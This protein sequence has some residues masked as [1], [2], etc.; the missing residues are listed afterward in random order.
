MADA[1][2]GDIR[3]TILAELA[4]GPAGE[5]AAPSAEVAPVEEAPVDE[6]A[7]EVEVADLDAADIDADDAPL[8]EEAPVED[9]EIE[10]KSDDP[11]EQK[12]LDNVRRAE[13]RMRE[14]AARRDADFQAE[15]QRWQQ[16]VDRVAEIDRLAAR[17]KYDPIPVLRALGVSDEDLVSIA[18]AAFSESPEGQKDPT[19][20][21]HAAAALKERERHDKLT[22]LEKKQ[23]ELEQSIARRE[24]EAAV[25]VEA[26][27]YMRQ[28]NA[29]AA[30]KHPLVSALIKADPEI[31]NGALLRHFELLST[32]LNRAPRPAEVVAAYDKAE[33]ARLTKLGIDPNMVGKA[34]AAAPA[35]ATKTPPAK[36]PANANEP[37]APTSA[38]KLSPTE[39]RESILA[40]LAASRGSN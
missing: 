17:V 33:R 2:A 16:Q 29:T 4:A 35:P 1:P 12:L 7:G 23:Q 3:S 28:L 10:L 40:E 25:R 13:K 14:A 31:A 39:E 6:D 9:E 30:S 18:Q 34:K 15:R 5:E 22:A 8:D 32:K 21:A 36:A 24:Q 27:Q 19:R 20:K 37:A 11:K 26:E 38:K